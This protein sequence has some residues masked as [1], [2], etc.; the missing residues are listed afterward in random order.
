MPH[1]RFPRIPFVAKRRGQFGPARG[2]ALAA[3]SFAQVIGLAKLWQRGGIVC[4][5][6][7]WAGDRLCGV[8]DP[9]EEQEWDSSGDQETL[10]F[11]LRRLGNGCI[12][13]SK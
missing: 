13:R 6:V 10:T 8:A 9:G 3:D 1:I 4:W 12:R 7:D 2:G 11:G 5:H